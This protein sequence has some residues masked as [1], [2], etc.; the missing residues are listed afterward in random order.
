MHKTGLH[1]A[2]QS[3]SLRTHK[4]AALHRGVTSVTPGESV[5]KWPAPAPAPALSLIDRGE[6]GYARHKLWLWSV[7]GRSKRH[8]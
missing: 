8:S 2:Q 1:T 6:R 3:A 4:Q 5:F 7:M